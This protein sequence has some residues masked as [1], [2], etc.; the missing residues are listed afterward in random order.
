MDADFEDDSQVP[1]DMIPMN[2]VDD[3]NVDIFKTLFGM[4]KRLMV[5][6]PKLD[7]PSLSQLNST[8]IIFGDL[9]CGAAGTLQSLK[10]I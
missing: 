1:L 5:P 7:L 4:Q 10:R 2:K 8:P 3:V 9:G 6:L